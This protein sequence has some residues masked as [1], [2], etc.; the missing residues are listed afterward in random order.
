[1]DFY[2]KYVP[3]IYIPESIVFS[4][5]LRSINL[6]EAYNYLPQI[7]EDYKDF[8]YVT[9]VGTTEEF[10]SLFAKPKEDKDLQKKFSEIGFKLSEVTTF[11]V[12]LYF[13]LFQ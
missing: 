12:V 6:Y 8:E 13:C 4:D 9:F 7:W 10:F 5:I 2:N 1:M 11:S 3:H